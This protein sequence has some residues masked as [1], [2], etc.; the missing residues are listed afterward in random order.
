MTTKKKIVLIALGVVV[1][2]GFV[3]L[4][5]L[6]R[7]QPTTAAKLEKVGKRNIVSIVS[8]SGQLEPKKK[9]D[10]SSDITGRIVQ[11][12][13]R[14][15]EMVQKGQVVVKIDPTQYEAGVERAQAG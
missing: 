6:K 15:G 10:V 8:A 3:T 7:R 1:M 14:E 2:G 11:L 4:S 5:A 12:P 9:V 13:F